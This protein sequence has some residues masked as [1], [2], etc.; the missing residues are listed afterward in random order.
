M[1]WSYE[2]EEMNVTGNS[3][4]IK[5]DA[6]VMSDFTD[7][8]CHDMNSYRERARALERGYVKYH[9]NETFVGEMADVSKNFIYEVQ[10]DM[11][12]NRNLELKKEFLNM[13]LS[14]ENMFK[15]EV[16]P[17]PKARVSVE[18]LSNIKKDYN[19]CAN[20]IDTKGYELDCHAKELVD[21][22][23]KWGISTVPNYRRPM[24]AF[25][26]F[27]GHGRFLDKS[28]KKLE[29]FD[30]E[31]CALIDRMDVKGFANDLQRNIVHKAGVLDSMTVYQ[32]NMAK[33]SLGLVGFYTKSVLARFNYTFVPPIFPML[34]E[35]EIE[36]LAKITGAKVEDIKQLVLGYIPHNVSN[37]TVIYVMNY[38]ATKNAISDKTIKKHANDNLNQI[39]NV[40]SSGNY[41][42][43]QMH[44]EDVK[45]GSAD[46]AYSGC[47]IIAVVNALH[48]LGKDLN[49]DEVAALISKFEK[50][51]AV[52]NGKWGTTPSKIV[53]YFVE[54]AGCTVNCTTSV[55][56]NK[57]EEI[58]KNND[59][60]IVTLYNNENNIM[61]EVHTINIE[62]RIDA[63]GKTVYV[64][65]NTAYYDD[66]NKN[67]MYDS[68]DKFIESNPYNSLE[69]AIRDASH[70][71]NSSP[72]MV[73]GISE[74]EG[75]LGD[76]NEGENKLS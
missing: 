27:C 28:I 69:E 40:Y 61:D 14:I 16:D 29:N 59:T 71:N 37:D 46:M 49:N 60:I 62:K 56:Y 73:I 19:V 17:S 53:D 68:A 26:E 74:V 20:V 9:N 32:P 45:Y 47:E 31:A 39:A 67:K 24:E 51:G 54:D 25:D 63:S 12:H 11:L 21:A 57:I 1:L 22:L 18:T 5:Y 66:V 35:N 13:C 72:I 41:I 4:D 48:S 55:D 36:R 30:Q 38:L 65:H 3:S 23:G 43:N 7:A 70:K 58:G 44:W 15:E 6:E 52:R 75:V 8:L 50:N 33:N 42:E 2:D 64:G 34:S 10:G 76:Y